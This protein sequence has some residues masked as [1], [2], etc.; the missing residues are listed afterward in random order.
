[1]VVVHIEF[2]TFDCSNC[3]KTFSD[4]TKLKMHFSRIHDKNRIKKHQCNECDRAFDTVS[5]MR[6]HID[7]V[8][9]NIYKSKCDYCGKAFK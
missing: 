8:H 7:A 1:M 9:K 3:E 4:K 5:G 6:A 2:Q